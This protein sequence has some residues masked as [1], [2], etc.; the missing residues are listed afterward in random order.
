MT[1]QK[2]PSV[3]RVA[4]AVPLG[5]ALMLS[6]CTSVAP[7][8]YTATNTRQ[9]INGLKLTA[10]KQGDRKSLDI[11]AIP[12]R[13]QAD[14][15]AID[16]MIRQYQS[17]ALRALDRGDAETF[18]AARYI[19][20]TLVRARLMNYAST[21]GFMGSLINN[22]D[23]SGT[24]PA[25]GSVFIPDNL[26]SLQA[27]GKV[28]ELGTALDGM[29][30]VALVQ[31][32]LHS[33]FELAANGEISGIFG[34]V[35]GA[36]KIIAGSE[37][38]SR[39]AG[40]TIG[41]LPVGEAYAAT[42]IFGKRYFVERTA[43]GL[44]L[45]NPTGSSQK[46]S[47]EQLSYI[48]SLE[49]PTPSRIEAGRINANINT[50]FEQVVQEG[51]RSGRGMGGIEAVAPNRIYYH[52]GGLNYFLDL[53]GN[54]SLID[55]KDTVAA[56]QKNPAYKLAIEM[57]SGAFF[58]TPTY[59]QF[60]AKSCNGGYTE[61]SFS[62]ASMNRLTL[63]CRDGNGKYLYSKSFLFDNS[64][65]IQSWESLLNDRKMVDQLKSIERNAAAAE[66]VAAFVPFVST[67]DGASRCA[68]GASVT[69]TVSKILAQGGEYN[70]LKRY[71]GEM[72]PLTDTIST[73]ETAMSCIQGAV[74]VKSG[75]AKMSSLARQ[76]R[77]G[78]ILGTGV[79]SNTAQ[80]IL[81][82]DNQISSGMALDR[83][84]AELT[85]SHSAQDIVKG[86]YNAAQT[87]SDLASLGKAIASYFRG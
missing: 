42:D 86:F 8:G 51:L 19:S 62:G 36:A 47:L 85:N 78:E 32:P 76:A 58:K 80:G 57:N 50:A 65:K 60:K 16:S 3:S 5:V 28:A 73:T 54:K 2:L 68:T 13:S 61:F 12:V 7:D 26:T 87:S 72:V 14:Q 15:D 21:A 44:V 20:A 82:F 1:T 46:V 33:D 17:V 27:R 56:Y 34:A 43:E 25:G 67:V 30:S 40:A 63:S 35:A 22:R 59:I 64:M 49:K 55:D 29:E 23:G 69:A 18:A 31:A 9:N 75:L 77:I 53:N 70:N 37:G 74:G 41:E 84:L 4:Y 79:Y 10:L 48:P 45:H 39:A 71:V 81:A 38:A 11:S 6:A 52:P 66:A 83:A 24:I